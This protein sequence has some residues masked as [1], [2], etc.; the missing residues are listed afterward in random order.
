MFRHWVCAG[1]FLAT[2]PLAN[3]ALKI[4]SALA[5]IEWAPEQIAKEDFY[6]GSVSIVDGGVPSLFSDTSVDLASNAETQSLRNYASHK[7]LRIIYTIAEVP[8][9]IIAYKNKV[10]TATD[11][12]GK[13]IGAIAST[14]SAYFVNRYMESVG[15]KSSD[16]T[17]VSGN[18]C[19]AEPCGSRTLPAMLTGGQI[20]AIGFWEPVIE[21]ASRSIGPSNAIIFSNFTV[22]REIFSL[23][24]TTEKLNNPA[25]R[26]EIVEF[27]RALEKATKLFR[28]EP[29]KVYARAAKAVKV[30][31]DLLRAVWDHHFWPGT[32]PADL[33]EVLTEEDKFIARTENRAAMSQSTLKGMIDTSILDEVRGTK[34]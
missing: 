22:Y 17:L 34:S 27:I 18:T 2:L 15:L 13:R 4:A 7:N 24:T 16:Y 30:K 19:T 21:I 25:K 32:I 23:H 28:D 6:N 12:K 29:E 1:A 9:R 26:K 5:V 31:E 11:L 20:D 3:A 33:L 10:K 8:Y 14:S